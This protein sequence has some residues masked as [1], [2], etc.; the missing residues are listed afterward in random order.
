MILSAVASPSDIN[1]ENC[2]FGYF[3]EWTYS[4]G[5]EWEGEW[6]ELAQWAV[7]GAKSK[8]RN[9]LLLIFAFLSLTHL[10]YVASPRTPPLFLL[11]CLPLSLPPS[12]PLPL[13]HS[14]GTPTWRE[15]FE[16]TNFNCNRSVRVYKCVCVCWCV[17]VFVWMCVYGGCVCPTNNLLSAPI[18]LRGDVGSPR[19]ASDSISRPPA[20]GQQRSLNAAG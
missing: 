5:R 10:W 8:E 17:S 14:V 1:N 11:L 20:K 12:L 13:T 15:A 7:L 6:E 16:L 19:N 18:A 9:L 2:F 3:W 4:R